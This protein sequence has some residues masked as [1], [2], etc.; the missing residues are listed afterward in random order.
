VTTSTQLAMC[1]PYEARIRELEAENAA[2]RTAT[3]ISMEQHARAIEVMGDMQF[4]RDRARE[5]LRDL[6]AFTGRDQ[7]Y[8]D[9]GLAQRIRGAIDEKRRCGRCF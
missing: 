5:M 2:L 4:E 6:W 3:P 1:E 8:V 9:H 7:R